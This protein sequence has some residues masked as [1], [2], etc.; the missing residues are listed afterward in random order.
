MS[1]IW[2]WLVLFYGLSKGVRDGLKKLAMKK[3]SFIEVLF[4]HSL[5]TFIFS[6]PFTENAFDISLLS[7]I[8][9]FIKSLV[10]FIAWMF[11]YKALAK[12]PL[13]YFGI[14]D[15]SRVMFTILFGIIVL[16]ERL[17]FGG[18]IG[19]ILVMLGLILVNV[20]KA[21]AKEEKLNKKYLA[22]AICSCIL[23]AVSGTMDK[24]YTKYVSPGQ[25]Q[26]W[27]ML[28]L[29]VLY[30]IYIMATKTEVS[31]SSIKTNPYIVVLSILLTL[32]D[33]ALFMANSIPDSSISIMTLIKQSSIL[34][35]IL[36][37][38]YVFKEKNILYRLICSLIIIAGIMI[39]V[40]GA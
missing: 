10:V 18:I 2:V 7:Y 11:S 26:F 39:A 13:S 21:D 30:L 38:K 12:M 15:M 33:R 36:F 5:L 1:Y 17:T 4:L 40:N 22:I 29:T 16:G 19:L 3:S 27:Y 31:L 34:V 8:L 32:S 20:P 28:F 24:V 25:L 23:N 35:T 14:I 9:I 6:I 37:G